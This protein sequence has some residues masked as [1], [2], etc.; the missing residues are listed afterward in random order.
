MLRPLRNHAAINIRFAH[1]FAQAVDK[2][3]NSLRMHFAQVVCNETHIATAIGYL[4][5]LCS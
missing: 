5:S 3:I 2:L 1:D 4:N